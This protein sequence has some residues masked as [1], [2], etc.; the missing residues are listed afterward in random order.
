MPWTPTSESASLTSSSLNGLITASIF[1]I[2]S[3]FRAPR[4]S[5]L[6]DALP[7]GEHRL[8]ASIVVD[9]RFDDVSFR[10][11]S[12]STAWHLGDST[13]I[14]SH[15][16]STGPSGE[17]ARDAPLGQG[18]RRTTLSGVLGRAYSSSA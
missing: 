6:S 15:S 12:P 17:P 7:K 16:K 2:W 4:A 14:L 13:W 8:N 1:F 11:R 9:I 18:R 5:S 10:T 3:R